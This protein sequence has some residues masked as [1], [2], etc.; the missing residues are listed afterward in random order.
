MKRSFRVYQKKRG[1]RRTGSRALGS[2]GELVFFGLFFLA[3]CVGLVLI[4]ATILIP[5]WRVNH[6]FVETTCVVRGKEIGHSKG[7]EGDDRLSARNS[8]R[9]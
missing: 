6:E 3:G 1:D 5:E 8:N 4:V 9:I 2:L 7:D